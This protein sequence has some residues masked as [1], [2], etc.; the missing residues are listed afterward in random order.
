[1]SD[2]EI[3]DMSNQDL[4]EHIALT[5]ASNPISDFLNDQIEM[6]DGEASLEDFLNDLRLIVQFSHTYQTRI[7]EASE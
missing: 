4:L 7:L 3:K 6:L 1:M 2:I 5:V